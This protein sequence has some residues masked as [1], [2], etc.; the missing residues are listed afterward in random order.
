MRR[1]SGFVRQIGGEGA[2]DD[3]GAV[4]RRFPGFAQQSM[5]LIALGS[6]R[7]RWQQRACSAVSMLKG[8]LF[9]V[10][11]CGDSGLLPS[12]CDT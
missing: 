9:A 4:A 10:L 7:N 6:G 3:A 8:A 5:Q 1:S 2:G 12:V 11:S